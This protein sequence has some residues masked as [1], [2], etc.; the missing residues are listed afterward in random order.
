MWK[1]LSTLS[2]TIH[3]GYTLRI[4]GCSR[5]AIFNRSMQDWFEEHGIWAK[6][7]VGVVGLALGVIAVVISNIFGLIFSSV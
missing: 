5:W 7:I 2:S 4:I 6:I 3:E 1:A